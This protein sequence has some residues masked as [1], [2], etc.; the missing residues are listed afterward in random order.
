MKEEGGVDGIQSEDFPIRICFQRIPILSCH[1]P[2]KG[3]PSPESD[4]DAIVDFRDHD[5]SDFPPSRGVWM[6]FVALD[7]A[8]G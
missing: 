4:I 5:C 8:L 2:D 6:P 3:N 1:G 7:V